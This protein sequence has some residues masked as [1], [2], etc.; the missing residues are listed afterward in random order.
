LSCDVERPVKDDPKTDMHSFHAYVTLS[1]G[2]AKPS[3]P[4]NR[5]PAKSN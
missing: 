4:A 2:E 5:S 1:V 3:P